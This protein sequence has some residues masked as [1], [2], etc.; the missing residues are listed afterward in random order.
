MV[1]YAPPAP[2]DA[3]YPAGGG[4]YD[5]SG[6]RE[7]VA[8]VERQ[9]AEARARR[10]WI[11]VLSSPGVDAES[12]R[13]FIEMDRRRI[14][15]GQQPY[16]ST[17]TALMLAQLG[18]REQ[19]LPAPN[20]SLFS[21]AGQDL[22]MLVA[23]AIRLPQMLV[24]EAAA[25]PQIPRLV[26]EAFAQPNI[27]ET[28]RSLTD[29]PVVGLLPGS[30]VA[31]RL[32]AGDIEELA[33]HPLFT[34][35]DFVDA[36]ALGYRMAAKQ[37]VRAGAS[38]AVRALAE[39][40]RR[41]RPLA[42]TGTP[43]FPL[44][45]L[46]GHYTHGIGP[47]ERRTGE[48]LAESSGL[49][50]H[51]MMRHERALEQV[52]PKTEAGKPQPEARKR[53]LY[54]LATL[55]HTDISPNAPVSAAE[56]A[57][58]REQLSFD[59]QVF[60]NHVELLNERDAQFYEH[61]GLL[62]NH[63]GEWY[64][65]AD[66]G[67]LAAAVHNLQ[68]LDERIA[69]MSPTPAR[70]GEVV[71]REKLVADRA[72]VQTTVD[73]LSARS[74]PAR[75]QPIISHEVRSAIERLAKSRSVAPAD[76]AT[77]LRQ[78]ETGWSSE[79]SRLMTPDAWRAS[80]GTAFTKADFDTLVRDVAGTWQDL[81]RAGFNPVFVHR[82]HTDRSGRK[83][84]VATVHPGAG[85][86]KPSTVRERTLFGGPSATPDIALAVTQMHMERLQYIFTRRFFDDMVK[87]RLALPGNEVQRII[88]EQVN[89]D[90]ARRYPEGNSP[91]GEFTETYDR[92]LQ[93]DWMEW[94]PSTAFPIR[95]P[96]L[97][98]FASEYLLP[99]S[100]AESFNRAVAGPS[101]LGRIGRGPMNLFRNS[102][103]QFS[104]NY[105]I[106]NILGDAILATARTDLRVL[107][108]YPSAWRALR[109]GSLDPKLPKG[110]ADMPPE[111]R[112]WA[113]HEGQK[114]A[115]YVWNR[116]GKDINTVWRMAEM[117]NDMSRTAV[118]LWTLDRG[119][120][121]KLRDSR[122]QRIT[123]RSDIRDEALRQ[124][125]RTFQNWG[126]MTPTERTVLRALF[127]FYGFTK[128][129][130]RY[131]ASFPFD[132]PMRAAVLLGLARDEMNDRTEIE[133][134]RNTLFLPSWGPFAREPG[135]DETQYGI[136]MGIFNPFADLANIFTLAGFLSKF[137]PLI[138]GSLQSLG[139]NP[140]TAAPQT[141]GLEQQFD[142][143]S[144]RLVGR[145]SEN[146]V[147][148]MLGSFVPQAETLLNLAL[149]GE[150]QR[151]FQA[152]N[153]EAYQRSVLGGFGLRVVPTRYNLATERGREALERL[154]AL[155]GSLSRGGGG[156]Y[157]ASAQ[158]L[159]EMLAAQRLNR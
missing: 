145:P 84:P 20:R 147:R 78:M 46:L 50:R 144:G 25:I 112:N 10:K 134:L 81:K 64:S 113:F 99:R 122:G 31:G 153:P 52:T 2:V 75:F 35:L 61:E 19:L 79:L 5:P 95:P 133:R 32:A 70:G 6:L 23:G 12:V 21:R 63:D 82:F 138:S 11:E 123:S 57:R 76:V 158:P 103:L 60:I 37:T 36:G 121:G 45:H 116:T 4:A 129:V 136:P 150:E 1:M 72:A 88:T 139:I 67:D 151:R 73:T 51:G 108:Y 15:A 18:S 96:R 58:W 54:Y 7:L 65:A 142:P 107:A 105:H 101:V 71:R 28:I 128:F 140:F 14:E 9:Q 90:L 141:F 124:Q 66:S 148:T 149:P 159:L 114:V 16:T 49:F 69:A 86:R 68:R 94:D 120:R 42:R 77:I 85:L 132:H 118:Y 24:R 127:P 59:E 41:A 119:K 156:T 143:R 100:L 109:S 117:A 74:V 80:G 38:D 91:P 115:D 93:R 146:V 39:R 97:Q 87:H 22:R 8:L 155:R 135:D 98:Q 125:Y 29:L 106:A 55:G 17:D 126:A 89:A 131:S 44:G 13:P 47:F 62:F 137:N 154:R 48:L 104:P 83:L 110:L 30:Y 40:Y 130:L 43:E 111:F 33:E 152:V 3:P 157:P 27:G 56:R 34:L 92:I 102:V 26:G 53:E